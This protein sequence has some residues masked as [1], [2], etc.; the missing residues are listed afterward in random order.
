MGSDKEKSEDS[1]FSFE[2]TPAKIGGEAETGKT[3]EDNGFNFSDIPVLGGKG[4]KDKKVSFSFDSKKNIKPPPKEPGISSYEAIL[5]DQIHQPEEKKSDRQIPETESHPQEADASQS[6]WDKIA[7][8]KKSDSKPT[9]PAKVMIVLAIAAAIVVASGVFTFFLL[10]SKPQP[11]QGTQTT[12]TAPAARTAKPDPKAEENARRLADLEKKLADADAA[13]KESKFSD[14]LKTYQ[15]LMSEGWKEK[16]PVILFSAAECHE[17]M[18]QDDEAVSCYVKCIGAGWKENALPY[19]RVSKLLNKKT[20]Y[21]DSIRYLEKARETFPADNSI[22]AQLANSYYLAGQTDKA[23]AELKKSNK[24]DLSL[25][26]IKLFGSVL[27]KNNENDHAREVYVYGMKKF[28]DLDCFMAAASL[29]DK[30]Q[31][32]IDIMSQAA[33][34]ADDAR[35]ST[36]VMRLAELLVQNGRKAE[37]AKQLDKISLDQLKPESATDFLKMLVNC[38]NLTKFT[39]EYKNAMEL[40]PKDFAMHRTMFETLL[41]NGLETTALDTYKG[42]WESKRKDAVAGYLYAKFLGISAYRSPDAANEDTFPIYKKVAELDPQFFE[43]FLEL[44]YFYT[45]ERDWASAEHAYSECVRI[46][47]DDRNARNLLALARER[48]G[49][50]DEAFDEYEKYLGTRNLPPEEKAAELIEI[51]QRLEKP[52]HAEKYLEALGKSPKYAD[53]YRIQTMKFKLIYGKPDDKDFSDPYPKAG[54]I[55][56]EYYLLSKGRNN[57]VL[58]MT[59]PP[60]E[61]PD[62]WKLFILWKTDK[63]GWQEG[64]DA[65][66]A[67]NKGAKDATYRI[68][69]DIWSG[70]K[71]PDDARKLLNKVHPDNEPLFFLM[72]AEKYR[73]DKVASKAKVC[74]QK[75]AAERHNPLVSVIDYYGQIPIK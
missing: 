53:N 48:A 42:W 27:Q 57:E 1:A 67:K 60:A 65:L 71:S 62:F 43:A 58:L 2:K 11:P 49:K 19:V 35:K 37:A 36:A 21:A 69:T 38:A 50:G 28:R 26:M 8:G 7:S 54:R 63:P 3:G 13:R 9:S 40:Y 74:Y 39:V 25:D 51:A 23:I 75:A 64:M 34:V 5:R 31:D 59:V 22:G 17:N 41:E 4:D 68:I 44:G 16:E 33:D 70:K 46:K 10:K 47:P 24:S 32:K 30:P 29:S 73:K 6:K 61:F 66:I 20:D 14:A 45:M 56:H 55:F 52:E 18:S 12:G 15:S 72:L